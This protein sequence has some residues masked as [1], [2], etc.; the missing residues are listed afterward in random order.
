MFCPDQ[1]AIGRQ[2][3]YSDIVPH[4]FKTGKV[5]KIAWYYKEL[6]YYKPPSPI[7]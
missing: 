3:Y 1:N 7:K 4:N 2:R 6:F 5:Y